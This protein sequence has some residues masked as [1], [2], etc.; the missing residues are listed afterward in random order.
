MVYKTKGEIKK[1]GLGGVGGGGVLVGEQF[2][3]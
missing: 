1:T 2:S 3:A